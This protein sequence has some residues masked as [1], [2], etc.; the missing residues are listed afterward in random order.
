MRALPPT[1]PPAPDEEPTGLSCPDCFG[2]LAARTEGSHTLLRFRCRTGH[3]YSAEEVIVGKERRL[4]EY[5]WA[6]MTAFDELS[7]F[8]RELA[9]RTSGEPG[10]P[11][12]YEE[13]AR[14][15]SA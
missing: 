4:E 13:R 12:A 14:R 5:L 6:A 1:A 3:A 9:A 11:R 7:T 10:A 15:A 8:L 2:M